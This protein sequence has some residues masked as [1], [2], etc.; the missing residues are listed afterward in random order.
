MNEFEFFSIIKMYIL[1]GFNDPTIYT[2]VIL[3]VDPRD[4]GVSET[5]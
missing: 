4:V 1:L 5:L 2:I 3:I